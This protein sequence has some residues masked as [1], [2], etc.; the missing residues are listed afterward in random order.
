MRQA[1]AAVTLARLG[2]ADSVWPAP[3]HSPPTRSE[4]LHR[5]LAESVQ[6]LIQEGRHR[7]SPPGRTRPIAPPSGDRVAGGRG[8]GLGEAMRGW[9]GSPDP[10]HPFLLRWVSRPRPRLPR[11]TVSDPHPTAAPRHKGC[12]SST[13]KPRCGEP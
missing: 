11:P 10:A 6:G 1:R 8:R 13:P 12:H 2:E 9:R 3:A 5:Q 4:E 7:V